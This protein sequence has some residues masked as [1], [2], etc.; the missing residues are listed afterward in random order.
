MNPAANIKTETDI[1]LSTIIALFVSIVPIISMFLFYKQIA[2]VVSS[3]FLFVLFVFIVIY[4][5][6]KRFVST[7]YWKPVEAK[8]KSKKVVRYICMSIYRKWN[9]SKTSYKIVIKYQYEYNGKI[10]TST[11]YAMSYK[12][13]GDCNFLYTLEEARKIMC[14]ITQNGKI[15]VYVNPS[16]PHES[17]IVQGKSDK[18]GAPWSILIIYVISICFMLYKMYLSL[19]WK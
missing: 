17:I 16:D 4:K 15:T 10:Y 5:Q 1:P 3:V 12:Y 6:E 7:Y 14:D 19:S 13:D 18:Y 11:K 2:V 8:I 9:T